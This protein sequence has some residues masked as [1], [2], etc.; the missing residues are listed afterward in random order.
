MR[1]RSREDEVWGGVVE[2]GEVDC[3]MTGAA[4]PQNNM[5]SERYRSLGARAMGRARRQ[6]N[7]KEQRPGQS[8]GKRAAKE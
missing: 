5:S 3:V 1:R 4:L 8:L 7:R 2:T 6:Y